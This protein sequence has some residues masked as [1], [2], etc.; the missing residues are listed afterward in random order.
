[1]KHF[2]QLNHKFCTGVGFS[3]LVLLSICLFL[4][5]ATTFIV[6][7][8]RYLP[9]I[10]ACTHRASLATQYHNRQIPSHSMPCTRPPPI[11]LPFSS[12][13]PSCLFPFT[14]KYP[15]INRNN[16][17]CDDGTP[18]YSYI[19]RPRKP[20]RLSYR[21]VKSIFL[22][23]FMVLLVPGPPFVFDAIFSCQCVYASQRFS[24]KANQRKNKAKK[25]KTNNGING[26]WERIY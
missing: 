8:Y 18:R 11:P 6:K 12:R 3:V 17:W 9:S 23:I 14:L 19:C 10:T 20:N 25:K 22:L 26:I 16:G 5:L 1:M 13:L 2:F 21:E 4:C 24:A 15:H 7:I